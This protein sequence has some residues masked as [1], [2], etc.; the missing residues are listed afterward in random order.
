[1]GEALL[2]EVPPPVCQAAQEPAAMCFAPQKESPWNSDV[3]VVLG[4]HQ[5][6][7]ASRPPSALVVL[8]DIAALRPLPAIYC[9]RPLPPSYDRQLR[10]CSGLDMFGPFLLAE[11]QEAGPPKA[12]EWARPA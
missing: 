9:L 2:P 5:S 8:A 3:A 4:F 10:S 12:A 1:M 7:P 11:H 6:S